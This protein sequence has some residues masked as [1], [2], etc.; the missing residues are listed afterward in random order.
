MNREFEPVV[1][2]VNRQTN[3][4]GKRWDAINL[5]SSNL[6]NPREQG[7]HFGA[8]DPDFWKFAD[9][10]LVPGGKVLDLG[11]GRYYRSSLF[12][13]LQGMCVT[14]YET[15]K[16]AVKIINLVKTA[17]DL[18]I[19]L[20][21]EDI[22]LADL[23]IEIYDTALLGQTFIHFPSKDSAFNTIEKVITALKPNGHLW[24]RAASKEGDD[25]K[26]LEKFAIDYPWEVRQINDDV[27]EAPCDC[28]GR[29]IQE[30]CL[31]F[32][33]MELLHFLNSKNLLII[34]SQIIP[35]KGQPNIMF[36]KDWAKNISV[37]IPSD[38]Q[39]GFITVLAQ[40]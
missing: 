19:S 20:K 15:Q 1:S 34:H 8:G 12:F 18:P 4:Y 26:E 5:L 31:F 33:A 32:N 14:G 36:G 7:W 6:R 17:Y 9:R 38:T 29:Y 39:F 28:S 10:L 13:A 35:E 3:A 40:K 2:K 24:L 27:Y 23:G 25:F 37:Y 11:V 22:S 16:E 21:T 30:P